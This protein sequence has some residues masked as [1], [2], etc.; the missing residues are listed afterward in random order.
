MNTRM[1]GLLTLL[2]A[3]LLTA[4]VS[5]AGNTQG[6]DSM[7]GMKMG[8]M[9]KPASR[10]EIQSLDIY[11]EGKLLHLL[12]GRREP[13]DNAAKLWYQV[14]SDGGK[15]WST[16]VRV[17]TDSKA[18]Y[19]L[20]RGGDA[21]IA[22]DGRHL[23]AAWTTEGTGWGDGGPIATAISDD[24]GRSWR[25]GPNPADDGST[26]DHGF[27]AITASAGR[28]Q[29]VWLDSRG[30]TGQGL[31]YAQS[32]DDGQHWQANL[33]IANHTCDCCWNRLLVGPGSTEYVLFRDGGP[34][35]MTIARSSDAGAHWQK[36]SAVAPFHWAVNVCPHV[37]GAL[38]ADGPQTLHALT[39]TGKEG[40]VG[41]YHSVSTDRGGHWTS[42]Q[43]VGSSAARHGDMASHNDGRLAVVWDES[44]DGASQIF[45]ETTA[46]GGRHWTSPQ[47]LTVPG[48]Y[49]THPRIVPVEDG[50]LALWTQIDRAGMGAL[51]MAKISQ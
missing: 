44:V 13:G 15:Q 25:P 23:I 39:W 33:T 48:I 2:W 27:I 8:G 38:V 24:G 28:F 30:N 43:P 7:Q 16:P 31:R 41:L 35:D 46:D 21:Q 6:D 42:P 40:S 22:A 11:A 37:G 3:L 47:R 10:R 20:H 4:S 19:G 29:M 26:K 1:V 12:T 45:A 34:R 5:L 51:E 32:D 49:A 36:L 18:P 9:E 14:S 17:D 50:Y